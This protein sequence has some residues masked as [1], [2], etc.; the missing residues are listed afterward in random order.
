VPINLLGVPCRSLSIEDLLLHLSLHTAY[1]DHFSSGLRPLCDLAWTLQRHSGRIDW[2]ALGQQA[3][4]WGAGRPLWLSLQLTKEFLDAPLEISDLER[5]RPPDVDP[6]LIS[7]SAAQVL[8]PAELGG[9]L[10]AVWAPNPW[11]KR[12]VLF[13]KQLF[14]P[15]NEMRPAYPPLARGLFWPLAYLWH[16]WIVLKRNWKMAWRLLRHDPAASQQAQQREGIN[17]LVAWLGDHKETI[18]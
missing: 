16:L 13:V 5:L 11:H 7:W 2:D 10:A 4:Q 9:K 3:G 8:H 6:H 15:A 12:L 14:P 17:T 18:L 1:L